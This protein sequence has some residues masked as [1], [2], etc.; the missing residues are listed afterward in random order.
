MSE[1]PRGGTEL[2]ADCARC[3]G[4]CCVAPAFAASADFALDKPA[5]QPC[6]N[7][8]ADSRCGIH[9]QL[10]ERGFPGCTVFDCFGAGQHVTQVTFGGRD[11]RD[12]PATASA[13][14]ATFA[15]VRPLHE[16]LWYLTEALALTPAGALRDELRA[17]VEETRDLTGGGADA[18]RDLDVDAYR[19]RMNPLLVRASELAR[20]GHDGVDRRGATLL[21]VDL[22]GADLVA[23]NLRGA[24][25]IGAD[26][27]GVRLRLAD[28]TGADLRGADLRGT[29]LSGALFLH[30]S[31]LDAARGDR[32]TVLPP[33]LRHPPHWSGL[34]ITPVGRPRPGGARAAAR[35]TGRRKRDPRR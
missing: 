25:L 14:F 12:D 33:A 29:D 13:M 23:A 24:C 19:G 11:W 17:A 6:P 27:R 9:P 15:V 31:Q 20:A 7:L 21:G 35:P 30:Q 28:L 5:G 16:L 8:G 10:R 32:R 26:L 3:V 4:L 1:T 22:R 34:G 2:R 18:L